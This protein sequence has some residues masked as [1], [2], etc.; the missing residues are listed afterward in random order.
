MNAFGVVM[1]MVF[2][3]VVGG[4]GYF[5]YQNLPGEPVDLV[6]DE[7]SATLQDKVSYSTSSQF[8]KNMRFPDNTISYAI[9]EICGNKKR[10]QFQEALRILKEE[11]VLEF[12]EDSV[13]PEIIVTCSDLMPEPENKGYFIAGEGGPSEIINTS[14]YAV[15][16]QGKISLFREEKCEKPNI[17]LHEMLHVLGFD[18]NDNPDSILFPTLDCEQQ[19]DRYLIDDINNLYSVT[20]KPDL[21][22]SEIKATKSG[23]YLNFEI[24]VVNQGLKNAESVELAVYADGELVI[25]NSGKKFFDLGN[26]AV[27]STKILNVENLKIGRGAEEIGFT[28]DPNNNVDELFENNNEVELV[29]GE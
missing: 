4:L 16:L 19:I 17:A 3:V 12:Y 8:Y 27:G 26:I 25:H 13:E 28:A 6:V 23:A 1:L 7:P 9:E 20:G 2:L 22:I 29:L 15:I 11:T 24:K 14:L 18:H 10:E 21:K 5:F